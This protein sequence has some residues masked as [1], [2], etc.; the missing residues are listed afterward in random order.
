MLPAR[1]PLGL[2]CCPSALVRWSLGGTLSCRGG[3]PASRVRQRGFPCFGGGVVELGRLACCLWPRVSA[4]RYV[5]FVPPRPFL[6]CRLPISRWCCVG[7]VWC[8]LAALPVGPPQ[9][10]SLP[11][12]RWLRLALSVNVALRAGR[13]WL[14]LRRG[15]VCFL[16]YGGFSSRG[17]FL[18]KEFRRIGWRCAQTRAKPQPQFPI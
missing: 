9:A 18:C 16:R 5:C 6:V 10:G 12:L 3:W 15:C 2:A 11:L 14:A 4:A 1:F 17:R 8:V 7:R 13:T